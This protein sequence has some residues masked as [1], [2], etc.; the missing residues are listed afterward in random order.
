LPIFQQVTLMKRLLLL[1][2]AIALMAM[3][4]LAHAQ[5]GDPAFDA[6]T[7]WRAGIELGVNRNS[8]DGY[9]SSSTLTTG[10]EAGYNYRVNWH[11]VVGGDLYSD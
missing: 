8:Y 10:L 6:W 5:G 3:P 9:G 1:S 11:L 4:F 2:Y 7:G